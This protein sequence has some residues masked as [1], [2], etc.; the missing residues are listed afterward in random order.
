MTTGTVEQT[1]IPP[2]VEN[3]YIH[4]DFRVGEVSSPEIK[5]KEV[6][7]WFLHFGTSQ[8]EIIKSRIAVCYALYTQRK[9]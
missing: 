9:S 1:T 6:L 4:D 3:P 2:A 7:D 8:K 5:N